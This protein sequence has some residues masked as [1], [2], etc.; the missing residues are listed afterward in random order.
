[1]SQETSVAG[2]EEKEIQA[3]LR[4]FK[5]KLEQDSS[6]TA[7]GKKGYAK[8]FNEKIAEGQGYDRL[9]DIL[10]T[11]EKDK[12]K[13]SP[14]NRCLAYEILI[15]LL[16]EEPETTCILLFNKRQVEVAQI[17]NKYIKGLCERAEQSYKHDQQAYKGDEKEWVV[18]ID[19][20]RELADY[21]LKLMHEVLFKRAKFAHLISPMM[22]DCDNLIGQQ[23]RTNKEK[24]N[25]MKKLF[26][27][28]NDITD[29]SGPDAHNQENRDRVVKSILNDLY[30]QPGVIANTI[31]NL[32]SPREDDPEILGY[33]IAL[34][35]NMCL[36]LKKLQKS[37]YMV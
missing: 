26:N 19:F 29:S 10:L 4:Y 34:I 12:Q 35:G 1:M 36:H 25:V 5:E 9:L 17:V 33:Q 27:F 30:E 22:L 6:A 3:L 15:L 8:N 23:G 24:I 32:N 20:L 7:F 37:K 14:I 31:F 28:L 13:P 21:D 18:F 16:K 11:D 2:L